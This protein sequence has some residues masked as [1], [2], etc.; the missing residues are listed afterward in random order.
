MALSLVNIPQTWNWN[1]NL[2]VAFTDE[3]I[4]SHGELFINRIQECRLICQKEKNK[5]KKQQNK[6]HKRMEEDEKK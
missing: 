6:N 5:N 4:V 3:S 2:D 1:D